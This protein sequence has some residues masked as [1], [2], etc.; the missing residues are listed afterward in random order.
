MP[1]SAHP[2]LVEQTKG[3]DHVVQVGPGT[4]RQLPG[5][6]DVVAGL[7]E[8]VAVPLEDDPESRE[9]LLDVGL[10]ADLVG[11]GVGV[12][13]CRAKGIGEIGH[14]VGRHSHLAHHLSHGRMG[15]HERRDAGHAQGE[16]VGRAAVLGRALDVAAGLIPGG[17]AGVAGPCGQGPLVP[18]E[19][20][21][22][23]VGHQAGGLLQNP[24][25]D[26]VG[27]AASGGPFR[28]SLVCA[29]R[30]GCRHREHGR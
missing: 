22:Q 8:R 25:L 14:Q 28:R 17:P 26:L 27:P 29:G 18:A 11:R 12:P 15:I 4:A 2:G 13:R 1:P 24:L 21:A 30:P 19:D 6:A 5:E 20:P 23:R 7:Q 10:E 3:A 9:V 16:A